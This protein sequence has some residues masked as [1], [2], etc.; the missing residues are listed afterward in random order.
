MLKRLLILNLLL[1]FLD[2]L[3]SYQAFAIGA[4][5]ANPFVAAAM[6]SWGVTAGLLYNKM[7]ACALLL[8][9]FALRHRRHQLALR[10]LS[11]TASIY[12]CFAVMCF[13]E[14]LN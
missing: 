2:G 12:S 5:E 10:A 7:L 1:Q 8:L 3:I 4:R 9:I 6:I 13:W 14:L 11:V